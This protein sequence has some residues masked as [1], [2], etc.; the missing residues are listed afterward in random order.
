MSKRNSTSLVRVHVLTISL[1][2]LGAIVFA[3]WS[4]FAYART[5][6][7]SSLV[8]GLL[9]AGTA[10]GLSFYLRHFI[11]RHAAR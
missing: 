10:A 8:I 11:R 1:S 7:T 3:A 5:K 4:L 6:E 9:A 2:I